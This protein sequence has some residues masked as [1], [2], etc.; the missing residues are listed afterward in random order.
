[1]SKE[2]LGAA[3]Q[4]HDEIARR[5]HRYERA[6]LG[7][8]QL[9]REEDRTTPI[10]NGEHLL[11]A[12]VAEAVT[13]YERSLREPPLPAPPRKVESEEAPTPVVQARRGRRAATN[14]RRRRGRRKA[15]QKAAPTQEG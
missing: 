1:M 2:M 13:A 11:A 15:E 9:R 4:P 6:L 3:L 7:I 8:L 5:V 14:G 10:A 12:Q